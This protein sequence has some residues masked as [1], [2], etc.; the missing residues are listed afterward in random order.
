MY[1]SKRLRLTLLAAATASVVLYAA[2]WLLLNDGVADANKLRAAR[3]VFEAEQAIQ[4][5]HLTADSGQ[6]TDDPL[7]AAVLGPE[8]SPITTDTGS[9]SSKITATNPNFAAAIVGLLREAGVGPGDVVGVAYT[10]S[11]PMLDV[12]TIA[13]LES[14]DAEPVI[15]SSIGASNWGATDPS[16]TILDVE[17]LLVD[18]GLIHH[19]SVAAS[20]GGSLRRGPMSDAGRELAIAAMARN[21]V[22]L[23]A[24]RGLTSEVSDH[25]RLYHEY[26]GGRPLK[27]FVN[28]GGGQVSTGGA[29]FRDRFE[30]GLESNA[31]TV[32]HDGNGLLARMQ[33]A[34][35]PTI[36][37]D[38]VTTL[39]ERYQLPIAPARTPAVGAGGPFRDWLRARVAAGL[40]AVL[41]AG[42]LVAARLLW[43]APATEDQ[44]DPYFGTA[45][46]RIR[47]RLLKL[48]DLR[49]VARRNAL[50]V[51]VSPP[52]ESDPVRAPA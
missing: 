33:R 39:A 49:I 34:R 18:R 11:F 21:N 22:Q 44:F 23:L 32:Q 43:L 6:L 42:V 4:A 51:V 7:Q 24:Q 29:S 45:G 20:V 52:L 19:R 46:M 2:V 30:P 35:I 14:L 36:H 25:I 27:A 9:L 16:F 17:T 8:F 37:I 13:A 50:P 26:A 1:T 12:A 3:S 48:A 15:V 38:Q 28:V 41:L 31:A 40:T 47:Q 10:G 5:A